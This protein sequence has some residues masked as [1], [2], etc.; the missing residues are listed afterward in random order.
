MKIAS[1]KSNN[2]AVGIGST[3]VRC[4]LLLGLVSLFVCIVGLPLLAQQSE[5]YLTST[6]TPSFA[7]PY[8]AE[9]GTVDAAS[10]NLHLEIPLGSFPQ[11]SNKPIDMKLSYD[12]HIWNNVGDI[13][14]SAW[15]PLT[16]A[17]QPTFGPSGGW[18]LDLPAM[19]EAEGQSDNCTMDY[20]TFSANGTQHWFSVGFGTGTFASG[21][22]KS[23]ANAYAVDSSGYLMTATYEKPNVSFNIYA[24]DG[25]HVFGDVSGASLPEDSNGNYLTIGQDGSH[26]LSLVDTLGRSSFYAPGTEGCLFSSSTGFQYNTCYLIP[27]SQGTSTYSLTFADISLRTDFGMAATTECGGSGGYEPCVITVLTGITLPDTSKYSF[28][29][30]CDSTTGNPA[31]NSNGGQPGYYGTLTSMTLP[32]G[33]TITYGY[34]N[35]FGVGYN[36]I[37]NYNASHWLTS[38]SSSAGHWSYTPTVTSPAGKG[39]PCL[40]AYKVGCMTTAVQRPDG[41]KEVTSFIVDPLGGSYPQQVL[42]YDTDG[43]TLLSTVNH[44]WDFTHACEMA[45]CLVVSKVF[46]ESLGYSYVQKVSTSATLPVPGGSISKQTT[47]TYTSFEKP[48]VSAINYWGYRTGSAPTFPAVPDK[49]TYIDYHTDVTINDIIHPDKQTVCNNVGTD[50]TDCPAGGSMVTQ[51][52]TSYDTYGSGNVLALV[53][54]AGFVNHDDANFGQNY[55]TRGNPTVV[56]RWVSGS[57]YLTTSL[58][59]DT[60]GQLVQGVDPAGNKKTYSWNDAFYTDNGSGA[61]T[62]YTPPAPTHAYLTSVADAIGTT[63]SG[64]YYGSGQVALSEDYN[65]AQTNFHYADVFDRPTETDLPIGWNL[66]TYTSHLQSDSYSPVGNLS[67]STS[68][69][70]CMHTQSFLDGVG[71]TSRTVQV[72]N[73]ACAVTV[74][75]SYDGNNRIVAVSHPN[76]G[77]G[78]PN[79]VSESMTYDGLGR[80]L[81]VKHPDGES[82][83]TA[84]GAKVTSLGGLSTQQNTAYGIG[85]PDVTVDESGNLKQQWLDGFGRIIEVD[86]PSGAGGLT[87]PF[88]TNYVYDPLGNLTQ[89]IE[90]VQTRTYSY[91]GLSRLTQQL[92]PE[93]STTTSGVTVQNPVTLS[94]VTTKNAVCSGNPSNP[95]VKTDASGIVTTYT[96]DKASRLTGKTHVPTTTGPESYTYGTSAALY[97]IG[98]LLTMTDPSGSESYTYDQMG[99]TTS[100]AKVIGGQTYNIGYLYDAGVS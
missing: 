18:R 23:S 62:P 56:K 54:A 50:T 17:T 58:S 30:D 51:T 20:N 12:S 63:Q 65:S 10:G 21:C 100:R 53:P 32:T 85:F 3:V 67:P 43:A 48:T 59:Y 97:N 89:V 64:Y 96:Y 52:K 74:T 49:A 44:A 45:A 22:S 80:S 7:A 57:T 94:Y 13:F 70:S 34:S 75:T 36:A 39:N 82:V 40:S 35:F 88:V 78:D 98:R 42:S 6:G 41:S 55:T 68:C 26:D 69:T 11:R 38:K 2:R 71:R 61:P 31:C 29:Y 91:D 8:P 92:T 93:A 5:D 99:R 90:G 86:E 1:S 46:D 4:F 47:Y 76:C 73:P 77:S 37:G 14:S 27:T 66:N 79:D 60:T 33:A 25:T 28:L 16:P 84:Y 72:N 24:P 95:C 83:Q 81:S 15:I 9:M 19:I 87:T